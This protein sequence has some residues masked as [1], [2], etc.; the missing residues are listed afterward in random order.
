CA[1]KGRNLVVCIDGTSNKFGDKNTNNVHLCGSMIKNNQQSVCYLMGV[2]TH[3]R[4]GGLRHVQLWEQASD[5]LDQAFAHNIS[6]LIMNAYS[7]LADRYN[8]GDKIF[9]FGFSRGAYQ[10][11]ALA[12]M[13]H[14]VGLITPGNKEQIPYA[15][16]YYSALN[17]GKSKDRDLADQFKRTFS[18]SVKIHFI[19]VWDTMSSVG[20]NRTKILPSSD[21]CDHVRYFHQALALD[22]RRVKFLPEYAC[23]GMSDRQQ[24]QFERIK[25]VWF[26]GDHSIM[27]V[28]LAR[29]GLFDNLF[30]RRCTQVKDG[31][32]LQLLRHASIMD[33]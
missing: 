23:R 28:P 16:E 6:R 22:E 20:I 19:G 3:G 7:W 5:I 27:Y 17:S 29:E 14:E 13:I 33:A 10:V 9:L 15:F 30:Q 8:D 24:S 32:T 31:W 1:R 21:T 26:A 2:G 11:R 18:M 12:G 25:E 4:P